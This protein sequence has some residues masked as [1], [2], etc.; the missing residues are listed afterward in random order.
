MPKNSKS[1]MI[2]NKCK[3]DLRFSL[4]IKDNIGTIVKIK[5]NLDFMKVL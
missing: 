4:A 3:N 5:I 2:H 1:D